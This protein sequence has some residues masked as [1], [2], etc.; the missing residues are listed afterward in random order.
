MMRPRSGHTVRIKKTTG[1]HSGLIDARDRFSANG[2]TDSAW[3]TYKSFFFRYIRRDQISVE[4]FA[5]ST[6]H[7]SGNIEMNTLM[8]KS[9]TV[10]TMNPQIIGRLFLNAV[11]IMFSEC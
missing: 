3:K 7:F 2:G 8:R 1:L 9:K 6:I 11:S 10:S 5:D 4:N